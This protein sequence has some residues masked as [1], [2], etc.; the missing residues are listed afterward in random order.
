ML[1]GV[2]LT[3]MIGAVN[4]KPASR[5]LVD[6]L[7]DVQVTRSAGQR[8]G[9][10]LKF[11]TG[12]QSE[13]TREL[14]P[15][16]F[17]DPPT[18]VILTIT[19]RG[20]PTVLMDGVITRHDVQQSSQPG[21]STLTVTGVDISQMMDLIDFSGIPLP[22][23]AE[24]RVA[25]LLAKYALYGVVPLVIPSPLMFVPNPLD[26]IPQQQGTDYQY[27][28]KLASDVGYVFYVEP[29]P[30]PGMNKAYWGP[31]VRAGAPQP[32][33]SVNMDAATNVDQLGFGFDG[34]SKS[35]YVLMIHM[36]QTKVPIP[37]PIP[38][39]SPLSPPLGA[40][41]PIPLS[42]K[43]INR[44]EPSDGDD[45]TGKLELAEAAM[46]GLARA[47]QS[48]YV[49]SGSGSLDVLRYGRLLEANKLV[50][51]RGAG[52]AYDGTYFVKSVT[53]TLRRGEFKQ[54]FSLSRNAHVPSS[55]KAP[56]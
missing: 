28:T 30:S 8:G 19:L 25:I 9:F 37:V 50:G 29:G 52:A 4:P 54:S 39:I 51:V 36:K 22:M 23:P 17:F 6:A 55:D 16:G 40:K 11:A 34:I 32:A 20:T 27:L 45:S 42:Y 41:V 46:R 12:I 1:K 43:M 56:L 44:G 33:L 13:I 53:S 10:Q 15:G 26:K 47:A 49:V 3:L 38:D 31:E 35:L 2:H 5:T 24:A 18:R 21:Q 7:V 48:S 14:L